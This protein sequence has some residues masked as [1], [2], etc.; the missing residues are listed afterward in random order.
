MATIEMPIFGRFQPDTSGDVH[1]S[2]LDIEMTMA[3]AKRID[4]MVMEYPTGSDIGG[5]LAFTIPQNYAGSPALVIKGVLDGT[6]ANTLAFGAQQIAVGDDETVDVA[7]ETEDLA[8][9][10]LDVSGHADEDL[11]EETITLTPSAAFQ[12]GDLV[13]LR[14]YRDDSVDDTTIDFLLT[15]LLFQYSDT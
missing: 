4:C 13:F 8:N 2:F 9:T 14:F 3:N 6:A 12:P 5:E 1:P 7:Y 10:D 11:L 15:D